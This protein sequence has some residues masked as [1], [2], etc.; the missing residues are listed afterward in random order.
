MP[1]DLS[2]KPHLPIGVVERE[3]GLPKDTLRVWERRYGFPMPE[4]DEAGERLYSAAD[5][6][7]LRLIKRLID[8]G[9]RPSKLIGAS[10][11]TLN[12]LICGNE[13]RKEA[14]HCDELLKL[15]RVA[16]ADELAGQLSK[17]LLQQGLVR[18]VC[19]TLA[20]LNR[21]VGEAWLRGEVQVFDEH[22]YSELVEN[23]LRSAIGL[24][25]SRSGTPRILLT[26]VP[27]EEHGLGLL[28]AEA[29]MTAEGALC[30]SLGTRTPLTEI[31]LAAINGRF[32]VV[33]L[34]FSVRCSPRVTHENLNTLRSLL[35]PHI[36]LWAGG[37]GVRSP[38]KLHHGIHAISSIEGAQT[39]VREWRKRHP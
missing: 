37:A 24:H 17:V 21:M 13:E 6:D 23:M 39:I 36:E 22:L 15:V 19:D 35:P 12:E 8:Q 16:H 7:K 34:S 25:S 33:A 3:T 4:R 1:K 32:D 29:M 27:E 10:A 18:F 9:H 26:T 30:V 38:G 5:V 31:Q 2:S 14:S 28:M 11:D 20:P